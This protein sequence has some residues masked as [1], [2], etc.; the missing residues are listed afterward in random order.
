MT[1]V[2]LLIAKTPKEKLHL[3]KSVSQ[4]L[5]DEGKR[6]TI[7]APNEESL[8]FLDAFLWGEDM[9]IPHQI[10]N[11]PTDEFALLTTQAANLNK[12]VA[13]INVCPTIAP[14]IFDEIYD[15][16]DHTS[17]EKKAQSDQKQTHYNAQ[18]TI[19]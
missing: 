19:N 4:K 11:R 10:A 2:N 16:L 17:P 3:I 5:F 6:F 8:K 13:C 9:F 18:T 7:L 1:K 14:S 12:S 15:L